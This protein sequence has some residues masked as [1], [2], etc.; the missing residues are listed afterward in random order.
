[1]A[2]LTWR[3]HPLKDEAPRSYVVLVAL[4]GLSVLMNW[5]FGGWLW[6]LLAAV[7]LMASLAR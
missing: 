6:S 3:A 2:E 4:L 1:M 7:L 5:A